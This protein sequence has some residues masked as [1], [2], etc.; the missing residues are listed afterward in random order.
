MTI[1]ILKII[2]F[3]FFGCLLVIEC[4]HAVLSMIRKRSGG[5]N[6]L[7]QIKRQRALIQSQAK[8]KKRLAG[9]ND[10]PNY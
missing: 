9:S 8:T 3:I 7:R 4:Y 1:I 10:S 2:G 6:A 5:S